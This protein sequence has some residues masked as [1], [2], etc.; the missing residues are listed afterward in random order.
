[1][2]KLNLLYFLAFFTITISFTSCDP[3]EELTATVNFEDVDLGTNGYLKTT[4]F[5]SGNITFANVFTDWGGGMTSWSGFAAS[6]LT[7]KT[8][9]GYTN[10]LSVY[11]SA[12]ASG[13]K[14]AVAYSDSYSGNAF[15]SFTGNAT[16]TIKDIAVNNSTYAYLAIKNGNSPAKKFV[17]GDWFKLI[18][19]GYDSNNIETGRVN[20]YLAD[21]R[22][23]K[24]FICDTW[25]TIDV[26]S[27]G[28]VHKV[29]F[30]FE[31]SD[32]GQYGINTPT[33]VCVDDIRYYLP[34]TN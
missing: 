18:I 8:T 23:G 10:E 12:G 20:Y 25:T 26:R 5:N 31:S 24:S 13:S 30:A 1:M 15:F 3:A 21:F 7:D 22:N 29:A 27:L 16:Y 32:T 6:S 33:Y 11:S 17:N 4:T 19:I 2:R 28:S 34:T 14:F 9:A